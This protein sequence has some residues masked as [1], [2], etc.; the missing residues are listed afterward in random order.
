MFSPEKGVGYLL[1]VQECCIGGVGLVEEA[2]VNLP[3]K[4]L[5]ELEAAVSDK[6]IKLGTE[7]AEL[8]ESM[9]YISAVIYVFR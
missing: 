2:G 1:Q 6:S 7:L 9:S 5:R 4:E 8:G 3:L